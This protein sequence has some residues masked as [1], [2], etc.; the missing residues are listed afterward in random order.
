MTKENKQVVI[1]ISISQTNPKQ[2]AI[3]NYLKATNSITNHA[4]EAIAAYWYSIALSDDNSSND[5]DVELALLESLNKLNSQM[6]LL[7]DYHRVKRKIQVPPETL[8]RLGLLPIQCHTISSP[9]SIQVPTSSSLPIMNYD[10]IESSS[11]T[12]TSLAADLIQQNNDEDD[13]WDNLHTISDMG[14]DMG[15]DS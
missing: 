9:V 5:E 8:M 13:D 3:L 14:F 1:R 7:V 12:A 11:S 2:I 6:L 10:S 4:M 15:L